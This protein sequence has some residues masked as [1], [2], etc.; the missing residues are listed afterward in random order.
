[1]AVGTFDNK[2]LEDIRFKTWI[3]RDNASKFNFYCKVCNKSNNLYI[4][5]LVQHAKGK[6]H[7]AYLA[8]YK[9]VPKLSNFLKTPTTP[10]LINEQS[11]DAMTI[12]QNISLNQQIT[13]AEIRWILRGCKK[14]CSFREFIDDSDTFK[15]MFTDSQIASKVT[16]SKTKA[17]YVT[18][19][20]I[21]EFVRKHQNSVMEKGLYISVSCDGTFVPQLKKEQVDFTVRYFNPDTARVEDHYLTSE[22]LGHKAATD[23]MTAF[24]NATSGVKHLKI[25]NIGYDGVAANIKLMRILKGQFK[26]E[27]HERLT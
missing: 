12:P 15:V 18:K 6:K 1:M 24:K 11:L 25:I 19:Y 27:G 22:F 2:W 3:G 17:M 23:L 21:A 5:S 4:N 26:D 16:F 20:G 14:S 10:T 9:E 7:L 8:K 13:E